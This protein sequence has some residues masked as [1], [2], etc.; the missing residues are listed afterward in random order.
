MAGTQILLQQYFGSKTKQLLAAAHEAVSE[1]SG[2]RGSHREDVLRIYLADI[3]PQRFKAGRGMVYGRARH[4]REA[5]IVI[6]DAQNYPSLHTH[7]HNMF[8]AESVR[9]VI[10]VKTRWSTDELTDIQDKCRSVRNIVPYKKP[11]LV[12]DVI[13]LQYAV[14]AL[15]SGQEFLGTLILPHH[16]ATGAIV[17]Y[18]G[19]TL[20]AN[21]LPEEVLDDA[22]DSWPDVLLLLNEGQVILKHYEELENTYRGFLEFIKAKDD[23]LL[24]FTAALLGLITERSAHVEDPFY[25]A[26]YIY[27]LLEDLPS[28]TVEFQLMGPVAGRRAFWQ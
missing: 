14:A 22:D 3:L 1:H 8:F 28:E 24:V 6:W 26:E 18:G 9:A 15:T 4:S 19:Q 7:G 23:A 12:D 25:L 2:L 11:N 10:E 17:L 16:I 27:F 20:S 21:T 5:D 13:Q